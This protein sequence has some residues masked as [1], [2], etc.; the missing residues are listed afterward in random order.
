MTTLIISN[1]EMK[2]ITEIVKYLEEFDLLNE[3][4]SKTVENELKEQ[5][6]GFLDML[7]DTIGASLLANML[8][9][10]AKIPGKGVIRSGEGTIR[11]GQVF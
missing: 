7:A 6:G 3:V 9:E 4:V 11:T 5:K 2:D 10:K 8:A 1:K